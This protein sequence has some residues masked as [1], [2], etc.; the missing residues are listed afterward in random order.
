MFTSIYLA[1]SFHVCV[2]VCV[3]VCV[4]YPLAR[5]HGLKQK[6]F[7]HWDVTNCPS[8]PISKTYQTVTP[9]SC[10]EPNRTVNF[11]NRYTPNIIY[12]II[13]FFIFDWII[14][15]SE[16]QYHTASLIL[17]ESKPVIKMIGYY[18]LPWLSNKQ[19][20]PD[21]RHLSPITD[22]QDVHNTLF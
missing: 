2:C 10:I 11:V 9:L 1:Q 22:K 6:Y 7:Q 15:I 17:P 5:L 14:H 12:I 4:W 8:P 19:S 16:H 3:C 13:I 21:L 20:L 18:Y